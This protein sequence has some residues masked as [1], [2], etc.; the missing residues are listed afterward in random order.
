MCSPPHPNSRAEPAV[1]YV[2]AKPEKWPEKWPEKRASLADSGRGTCLPVRHLDLRRVASFKE[3][4]G[5]D[6]S[7]DDGR[8]VQN[9]RGL[10]RWAGIEAA[11]RDPRWHSMGS[12]TV[13]LRRSQLQVSMPFLHDVTRAH[14]AVSAWR[15]DVID[16]AHGTWDLLVG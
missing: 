1:H 8:A 16:G 12:T 7:G 3:F 5:V 15:R 14:F 6:L 9:I 4:S 2:D 13:W 11:G 10:E